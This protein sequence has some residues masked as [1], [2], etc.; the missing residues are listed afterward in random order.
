LFG[1]LAVEIAV[2]LQR[3]VALASGLFFLL[4]GLTFVY[5]SFYCMRISNLTPAAHIAENV[6]KEGVRLGALKKVA[7]AL[8]PKVK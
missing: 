8:M 6:R 5:R 1:I 4:I 2:N 3:P 7:Q